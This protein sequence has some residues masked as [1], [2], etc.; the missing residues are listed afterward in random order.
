MEDPEGNKTT[1]IQRDCIALPANV[2][3]G[4]CIETE[5][6]GTKGTFCYCKTDNCNKGE[7]TSSTSTTTTTTTTTVTGDNTGWGSKIGPLIVV[8]A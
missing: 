1:G 5:I 4:D 3:D 2:T 8:R 6:A 7:I